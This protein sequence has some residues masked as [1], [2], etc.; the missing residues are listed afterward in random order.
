VPAKQEIDTLYLHGNVV[1]M[2]DANPRADAV[3]TAGERIVAVGQAS[4]LRELA[5]PATR[6]VDLGGRTMIPGFVEPHTHGPIYSQEVFDSVNLRCPPLG[7]V[8]RFSTLLERLRERAEQTPAG[9]WIIGARFDEHSF[10]D[11]PRL[12]T[13]WDLDEVSTEHPIFVTHRSG[14]S[15]AANSHALRLAGIDENTPDPR[16]GSLDREAGSQEP[17]G[18]LRGKGAVFQVWGLIPEL[19]DDAALARLSISQNDYLLSGITSTHDAYILPGWARLYQKALARDQLPVRTTMFLDAG[20]AFNANGQASFVSGFGNDHLRIGAVKLFADGSVPGFTGWLTEPYLTPVNGDA[21]HVGSPTTPP[22]ALAELVLRAHSQGF[23]V[24]IHA[25][26]DAGIDSAIDAIR[27]AQESDGR[28]DARHR[29]EHA[30]C[31]RED[32]LEAMAELGITPSFFI[33]HVYYWGD[34]YVEHILGQERADRISPLRSAI[35]H[36]VR[37]SVHSDS[38]HVPA[39]PLRDLYSCVTRETSGGRVLGA[40]QQIDVQQALR[41]V[42]ID[43]AWQSFTE[44]DVGSIEPGKFADLT[45][46]DEDPLT[47][48]A[49][50]LRNIGVAEVII[51]GRTRYDRETSD[52]TKTFVDVS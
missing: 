26:G 6:V 51:G 37:F 49:E 12:P 21:Q 19:D 13:R 28:T 5:G 41:A 52:K 14:H 11:D 23:Q 40:D 29:I 1:T 30:H 15:A 47:T 46:L 43:A 24:A 17:N 33:G 16:G 7:V 27:K 20:V 8:D 4:E 32:Q 3:A 45:I 35:E 18:V 10:T 44:Q 39:D 2:D 34:R 36:G 25:G 38:P 48:P 42:T 9:E 22:D 50:Q 31:T